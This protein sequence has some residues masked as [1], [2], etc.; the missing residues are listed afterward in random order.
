[1]NRTQLA[2]TYR[3]RTRI[4]ALA[5]TLTI[6]TVPV[7]AQTT[8]TKGQTK[9]PRT[10][11]AQTPPAT[12]TTPATPKTGGTVTRVVPMP[13]GD[14]KNPTVTPT[15]TT[16]TPPPP[17]TTASPGTTFTFDYRG[18]DIMNVL[19]FYAQMSGLN[20]TVDPGLNGQ[21]TIINPK[22]V[23]L[24]EAFKILQSVLVVRGFTAV[25]DGTV[26][27]VVP[28]DRGV[29]STPLVSNGLDENGNPKTNSQNQIMTQ[30]IPLE[31]VDAEA[32]AKEL[33]PLKSVG[34]S[35]IGSPGTNALIITDT[36]S[37]VERFIKMVDALDKTS[38]NTE[39]KVYPLKR[40]EASAITDIINNLYKQITTRGRGA[41][42]PPGSPPPQPGQ[43]QQGG[44]RPA[45]VAVADVRTNSVIVVASPDNQEQVART[46]IAR[47]DDDDS[48]TL[49]TKIRKVIY[50]DAQQVANL[51]NTV[52]SNQRASGAGGGQ[53]A[54]FGQRNFGG[55]NPF[56]GGNDQQQS[57]SST[58][59]FGKVA[60]DPRTNTLLISATPERMRKISELIDQLDVEVPIESTTFVIPLM[61]AQAQDVSAALKQAFST[62]NQRSGDTYNFGGGGNNNGGNG[63]RRQRIN[64]R[65]NAGG[66]SNSGRAVPPGPP[67]APGDALQGNGYDGPDSGSAIPQGVSGTMTADG[68]VPNETGKQG[69][70]PERTRQY[71]GRYGYGYGGGGRSIGQSGGPQYGRGREGAYSNLL[72][73]QNNVFVTPSPGGDSIV[74]TTTPDN[75]KTLQEL[76]KQLDVVQ[77][78][79]LIEVIVAEVTLD[80]NQKLGSSLSGVFKNIFNRT[81]NAQARLNLTPGNSGNIFDANALGGQFN[82][83]GIDYTALLQAI[84]TD[85]KVKVLS[86][87]SIF[88]SNNQEAVIEIVTSIPYITGQNAGAFGG[89]TV[90]NTV[91][92]LKVGFNLNVLPVIT[93][94][95]LVTI[96]VAQEASDLLRFET[97]GTG[98]AAI[99]VPS[100]NVRFANTLVTVQD[101]ETVAIGGLI[102][103]SQGTNITKVPIL[104]EIPLLGQ[105]FRAREKTR[106]RTELVIFMTPR[107]VTSAAESR[108]MTQRIGSHIVKEIPDLKTQET[109]LNPKNGDRPIMKPH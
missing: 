13:K 61:N 3:R 85:N 59:P 67:N 100:T 80:Q 47:L 50:A 19:R 55:F 8:P 92:F 76:V 105:F 11:A 79:V 81:N 14:G 51:V 48:N 53:N 107:I 31:N 57:V 66:D 41:G 20:V 104:S 40:A 62:D 34:A 38:N 49:D 87:P 26:L 44:G 21:V 22:P 90:S 109:N 64:R 77:R 5:A 99:R 86:T 82:V 16:P 54:S 101:G 1:M 42:A 83:T 68:F 18:A 39:L 56:G 27:S 103:D 28:L 4:A 75:I 78:Q 7:L 72:Q 108:A 93:R 74:V 97:L 58:D 2:E 24:D 43:P 15:A 37:N 89:N 96:D 17:L 12:Q 35:L 6:G 45:V 63:N 30:V 70:T 102:R 32:L 25:K 95:G 69:T 9:T 10:R 98:N 52:L 60:A 94:Q 23:S 36:A 33:D 91:D 71:Y 46:I 84:S 65:F 29:R 73:L 106:S 88:T